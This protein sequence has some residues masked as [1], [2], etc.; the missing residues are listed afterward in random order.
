MGKSATTITT[1][2][3]E[4]GAAAAAAAAGCCRI[5]GAGLLTRPGAV[6]LAEAVAPPRRRPLLS[7]SWGISHARGTRRS[8]ATSGDTAATDPKSR[9]GLTRPP[10]GCLRAHCP[11][12]APGRPFGNGA[13]SPWTVSAFE[14]GLTGV[15]VAGVGGEEGVSEEASRGADLLWEEEQDPD[16]AA[17][18]AGE[19]PLHLGR[20][21]SLTWRSA[22]GVSLSKVPFSVIIRSMRW[23][24]F[25]NHQNRLFVTV[26]IY[27]K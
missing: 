15:E 12:A 9:S 16:S 4:A 24:T 20:V 17:V 7:S 18:R 14:A 6:D 19:S 22:L 26:S 23:V 10:C 21:V 1:A 13:T 5:R 25:L 2:R 11:K 3:Y 27:L 8:G